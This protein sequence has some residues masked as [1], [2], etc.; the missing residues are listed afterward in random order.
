MRHIGEFEEAQSVFQ[1]GIVRL[2]VQE[3][4]DAITK[5]QHIPSKVEGIPDKT[6]ILP[7]KAFIVK[8]FSIYISN[9]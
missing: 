1:H 9:S 3:T 7:D 6:R 8:R 2:P 4:D 5:V